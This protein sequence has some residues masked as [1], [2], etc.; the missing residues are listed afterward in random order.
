MMPDDDSFINVGARLDGLK[1]CRG[2]GV[3]FSD[4]TFDLVAGDRLAIMGESSSGKSS[5]LQALLG[6][7]TFGTRVR[8]TQRMPQVLQGTILVGGL[9][10]ERISAWPSWLAANAGALFQLGALIEG[11]SLQENLSFTFRHPSRLA[12]RNSRTPSAAR[13]SE[14][15]EDVGLI[16]PKTGSDE[17]DAF[18]RTDVKDLS[19]GQR[20]RLA[21]ARALAL[22]S[23]I[24]LLDE[25]TSG[26]DSRTAVLVADTIRGLSER[27]RV[28]VLC[29]TH[30]PEFVER[31]GCNKRIRFEQ[32]ADIES[33]R[34]AFP[35]PRLGESRQEQREP[36]RESPKATASLPAWADAMRASL[37]H[38]GSRLSDVLLGSASLCITVGLIAGAGLTI[39][40]VAAPRLLQ[41]FLAQG[42]VAGVF[43]GMG[44]I[45][46]ALLIIDLCAS[47]LTGDLAQRKHGERFEYLRLL[48]IRPWR[49][50]G[51]PIPAAW[52]VAT[53]LPISG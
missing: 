43:L 9:P 44:T 21:L 39:Q 52:A 12:G 7:A 8:P 5:L 18:L 10:P 45:M 47:G 34:A 14:L 4:L 53:P 38:T 26:L 46:P 3:P 1:L 48:G 11:R 2:K 23:R 40:A 25:L 42:V 37:Q 51:V 29:T 19:D 20:K 6:R 15:L 36:D 33:S 28:A 50:P 31:L 32:T 30:D 13:L 35:L 22:R 16:H 49:F 17:R 27:D 41:T 24:L